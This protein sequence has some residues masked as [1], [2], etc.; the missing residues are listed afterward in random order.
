MK[1]KTDTTISIFCVVVSAIF[2]VPLFLNE[3]LWHNKVSVFI[4]CCGIVLCVFGLMTY[5]YF[6]INNRHIKK[7][8]F[9]GLF[10]RTYNLNEIA[11][12]KN[13]NMDMTM[14][15]NPIKM[16][17]LFGINAKKYL[18]FNILKVTF[19]NGSVLKIDERFMPK[20]DFTTIKNKIK[21]HNKL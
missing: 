13:V 5:Q 20:Q 16:L 10:Y 2:F 7:Y 12:Y 17:Y 4:L 19:N 15:K 21:Y 18:V 9:L 3:M 1:T 6:V 11:S 8:S 14:A